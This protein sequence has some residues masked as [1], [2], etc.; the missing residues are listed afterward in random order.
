METKRGQPVTSRRMADSSQT[1]DRE[2]HSA[3]QGEGRRKFINHLLGILSRDCT[4]K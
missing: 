4:V 1:E 3:R 2:G